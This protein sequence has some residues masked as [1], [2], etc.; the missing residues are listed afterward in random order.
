MM[1]FLGKIKLG[2]KVKRV[3]SGFIN[4]ATAL[5]PTAAKAAK[6]SPNPEPGR[7]DIPYIV[8]LILGLAALYLVAKQ[9]LTPEELERILKIIF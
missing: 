3:A 7:W 6:D 1:G 9:I 2:Y 5:L 4:G 8:G